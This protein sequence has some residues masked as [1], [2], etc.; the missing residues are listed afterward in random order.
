M[1]KYN[2]EQQAKE[3]SDAIKRG[4]RN[5]FV[6]DWHVYYQMQG[7]SCGQCGG[8]LTDFVSYK[9]GDYCS[10]MLCEHCGDSIEGYLYPEED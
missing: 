7:D 6:G 4:Y 2:S 8:N 5:Y 3:I 9:P 10:V 1:T